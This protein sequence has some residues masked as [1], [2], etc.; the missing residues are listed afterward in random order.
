MPGVWPRRVEHFRHSSTP[1]DPNEVSRVTTLPWRCMPDL[2][3]VTTMS[4]TDKLY[5]W[6]KTN[7]RQDDPKRIKYLAE[8]RYSDG[9]VV[10]W[11][12]V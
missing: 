7:W 3:E 12:L 9:R 10:R 4:D 6:L 5:V 11:L 8:M 1:V 2:Q